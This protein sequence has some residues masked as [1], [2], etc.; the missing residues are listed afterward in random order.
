MSE[1]NESPLLGALR[2]TP[3]VPP[4]RSDLVIK[5]LAEMNNQLD[6]IKLKLDI[7]NEIG[8]ELLELRKREARP[9]FGAPVRR[10]RNMPP[11]S[12]Y[13]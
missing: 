12:R 8:L 1:N 6:D 10:F 3:E 13:R 4:H 11:S 2:S 5:A 9:E 7:S